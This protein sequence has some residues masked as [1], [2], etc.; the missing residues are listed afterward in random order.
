VKRFG[1][2][3]IKNILNVD[4]Y[5]FLVYLLLRNGIDAGDIFVRDSSEYKRLEEDILTDAQ[6]QHKE[7]LI[8]S[9]NTPYLEQPISEILATLRTEINA[10]YKQVNGNIRTGKNQHIKLTKRGDTIHWALQYEKLDEPEEHGAYEG[11]TDIGIADILSFVEKKTNCFSAFTHILGRYAK[12]EAD[13]RRIRA[14]LVAYG[15]NLGLATM[16]AISDMSHQELIASA[17]ALFRLETLKAGNDLITNAMA[18]LVIFKYFNIEDGTLWGAIDGL[19]IETQLE[20]FNAR[21]SS[22]YFGPRKGVSSI[23]LIVNHISPNARIISSHDH[24]GHFAYD[25]VFNNTSEVNPNRIS[26]DRHGDNRI[27][28]ALLDVYGYEFAPRYNNLT[29]ETNKLY[30][31]G[32]LKSYGQDIV[33]PSKKA[34]EKLIIDE[35]D[36]CLRIFVSLGLKTTTQSTIVRK[37]CSYPRKSRTKK[38]LWELDNLLRTRNMLIYIDSLTRRRGVQ[39]ATNRNESYNKLYRAIFYANDGKFRVKTELEQ[40]IWSQCTRFLANSIIFYNASI[41]SVLLTEA[42]NADKNEEAEIIKRV[43]P[44]AWRHINLYGRFEFQREHT[45][46]NIDEMIK[47]LIHEST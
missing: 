41:L 37:L 4:K 33:R 18:K 24:E 21:H 38:A 34:K 17:N 39:K 46:I 8:K 45:I 27:N 6:W 22:K 2:T 28:H 10:L 40:N 23:G 15:E 16:A 35:W 26:T 3:K 14:C 25:L 32:D 9:L 13:E 36:N 43:S 1:R 5:E 31:F 11:L 19:K 29:S 42:E 12:S 47:A 30:G 44:I 7:A 20:T